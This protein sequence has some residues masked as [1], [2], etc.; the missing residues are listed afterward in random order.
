MRGTVRD[1]TYRKVLELELKEAHRRKDEFLATLAHELR[2]PLSAISNSLQVLKASQPMAGSGEQVMGI[3]E[4]QIHQLVRL[5][6][7]LMDVSRVVRGKIELRRENVDLA[8]ILASSVETTRP[9]ITEK[10]HTLDIAL[11][12]ESLLVHADPV[13]LTQVIG[14]LLANAAKYTEMNGQ[15]W[16]FAER[17]GNDVVL[18][19]KDTGIGIASE[20]LSR[21]FDLFVQVDQ[22]ADRSQG[23]LGIG[24]TL[25][26]NLVEM[27]NGL[28]TAKSEGIGKGSEFLIRL[29]VAADHRCPESEV[30]AQPISSA[31]ESCR[32]LLVVDDNKDAAFTLAMLLKLKGHDV[33]VANSGTSALDLARTFLPEVVFLDLGMPGMG[34]LEV[35]ALVRKIPG[36]QNT[37]LVALTG[38]GQESD[39]R[40]TA[41]AGFNHHVVKPA[42]VKDLESILAGLDQA[43]GPEQ[44]V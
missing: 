29:P 5:V 35:A 3:M 11:P 9:L 13:R 10:G 43:A 20:M 14:N 1:L 21:I 16:L 40:R 33:R 12:A 15:I 37:V 4:R 6:D 36:L 19:I 34:G 42:D 32:R 44:A 22:A 17:D 26:R 18:H 39:R 8:T 31:F 30:Y 23:G 2:N 38:W 7:D 24:L 28:V 25:V 41:D 27:H